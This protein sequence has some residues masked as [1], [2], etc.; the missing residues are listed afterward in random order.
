[1]KII[2]CPIVV[3]AGFFLAR[4]LFK[5]CR[6]TILYVVHLLTMILSI[7][8]WRYMASSLHSVS[9]HKL[10]TAINMDI[11]PLLSRPL[12]GLS[13]IFSVHGP[14]FFYLCCFATNYNKFSSCHNHR[15]TIFP[16]NFSLNSV[17]FTVSISFIFLPHESYTA[18][19]S[20]SLPILSL[21]LSLLLLCYH[22]NHHHLL[23]LFLCHRHYQLLQLLLPLL[24]LRHDLCSSPKPSSNSPAPIFE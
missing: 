21:H 20:P 15:R 9:I 17:F 6:I 1:M 24:Q 13:S 22:D 4:R 8:T 11:L 12:I 23:L 2:N 7:W 19:L 16:L 10:M 18:F 14:V 3:A 5:N